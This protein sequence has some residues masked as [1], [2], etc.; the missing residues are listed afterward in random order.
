MPLPSASSSSRMRNRW[1]AS[2]CLAGASLLAPQQPHYIHHADGGSHSGNGGGGGGNSNDHSD[3]NNNNNNNNGSPT[4]GIGGISFANAFSVAA[5]K[6]GGGRTPNQPDKI[7]TP[8]D[9]ETTPDQHQWWNTLEPSDPSEC[10]LI[11]CQIT[12][13]YTLEHFA[14]FKTMVEDTKRKAGPHT[15]VISMLTG[16][17]LSPYLLSSVDKGAGMM[18]A[19]AKI[20][21][22]YV[23]WGNHE[24]DIDHKTTCRHVR[25]FPGIWLNSNMLDHDAMD[26]QQE[27]DVITLCSADESNQRKV[28]LCAVLSDDPDLYSHFKPPGAFGGATLTNPWEALRKYKKILEDDEGC[29]LVV[30][31]EHLYVPDDHKTCR[32]FDFPVVL[33]G[34]DHHRV[35]EVVEGTR[36]LK[37]GMNAV[38]STLLEIS[39]PNAQCESKKPRIR[40]RFVPTSDW[41]PDPVLAEENERA[42]DALIPLRNTQLA[43]VPPSFEPLS[44]ARARAEV[45]SMGRYLCSLIRSALNTDHREED[46][47]LNQGVD[48]VLLMGGNIRGNVESYPPG[49]FFSL[50]A[51]EAEIQSDEVIGIVTMPGWLIDQ[52]VAAT[53]AGDPIPGWMQYDAG[54]RQND[55]DHPTRVTHVGGQVL[56]PDQLYRVATKISDLTNGQSPPLTEYFTKN[57][58]LL[59]PQGAYTNIQSKLMTYFARNIWDSLWDKTSELID[60]DCETTQTDCGAEAR[61][62]VLDRNGEGVVTVDDVQEALRDLLGYSVDEREST[63]AET[64]HSYVDQSG[65]GTVTLADMETFCEEHQQLQQYNKDHVVNC[66]DDMQDFKP[67]AMTTKTTTT[68][69]AMVDLDLEASKKEEAAAAAA[70]VPSSSSSSTTTTTTTEQS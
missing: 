13:V 2:F 33:S 4:P 9:E 53:H 46:T 32:E 25:N 3:N 64:V 51:L 17:F 43:S 56:Q 42:Y 18:N 58:H 66:S 68:P 14:S 24:A 30:P 20:P 21:L 41:E 69:T 23:T 54:V 16:D 39:W 63:L 59:P 40:A 10:R 60:V 38:F 1:I 67:V 15:K 11:I 44:S 19:L 62:E 35:D 12:D 29:D 61:L 27:Y 52:G 45:C 7:T 31:L 8:P 37:P 57:P 65:D 6:R 5:T 55:P 28:G 34:H 26:A 47:E 22:D 48:A 36:L 50:E 70:A 49:S